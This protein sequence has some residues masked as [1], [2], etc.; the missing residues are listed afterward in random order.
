MLSARH[1]EQ[2]RRLRRHRCR[3][4]T[5][6]RFAHSP[7][8]WHR[9]PPRRCDSSSVSASSQL[10]PPL[11]SGR[12]KPSVDEA[13]RARGRTRAA[14]RRRC[15][16]ATGAGSRGRACRA[17]WLA[18][19]QIQSSPS[20]AA[21]AS[22]S[23]RTSHRGCVVAEALQ[24]GAPPQAARMLGVLPEIVEPAAAPAR[25]RGSCPAGRGSRPARRGRPRTCGAAE[26]A[27]VR[28]FC[29]STQASA[30]SP[31]ISSSQRY[32]SSSGAATVGLASRT[33]DNSG[34]L[35]RAVLPSGRSCPAPRR[36]G[37]QPAIRRHRRPSPVVPVEDRDRAPASPSASAGIRLP[38]RLVEQPGIARAAWSARDRSRPTTRN[39][40][41]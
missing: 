12:T 8:W 9:P 16:R 31:S 36:G 17:A 11:A 1:L 24:R 35:G 38:M 3:A 33:C 4:A 19:P 27:S 23:S 41:A 25:R 22:R 34:H 18:P 15:R 2:H 10:A 28:A 14:R 7:R 37:A 13:L 40:A 21:S 26:A 39:A 29:C 20:A 32:G 5:A 6:A 30:R